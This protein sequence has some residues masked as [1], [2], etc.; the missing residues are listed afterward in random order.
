MHEARRLLQQALAPVS[1]VRRKKA[2]RPGAPA[3]PPKVVHPGKKSKP[4]R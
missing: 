3:M 1:E 2:P 4:E